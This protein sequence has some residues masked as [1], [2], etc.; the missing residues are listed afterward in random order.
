MYHVWERGRERER[1]GVAW[2]AP[3]GP[4]PAIHRSLPSR[5][6]V[7]PPAFGERDGRGVER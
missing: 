7:F 3:R 4:W 6:I 1:K 5:G 2:A